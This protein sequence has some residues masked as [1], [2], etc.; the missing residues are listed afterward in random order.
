M[1]SLFL[2]GESWSEAKAPGFRTNVKV[3]DFIK[4]FDEVRYG[5]LLLKFLNVGSDMKPLR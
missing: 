1:C 3:A 2:A 5:F 4:A